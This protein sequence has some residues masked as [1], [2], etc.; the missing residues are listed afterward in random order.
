MKNLLFA[1]LLCLPFVI[2]AQ[3]D[4]KQSFKF[5]S[6]SFQE[7][8]TNREFYANYKQGIAYYNKGVDIIT[9]AQPAETVGSTEK[10][11]DDAKAQFNTALPFLEKA[12]TL[13]PKN[14]KILLA[15][16]GTYFALADYTKSD[17]FKKELDTL[18]KK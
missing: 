6:I 8:G 15:L 16:Q 14:E 11:P 9:K 17:S 3:G 5:E 12:Y 4:K 18:K 2:N 13:N 10:L 1:L 7:D